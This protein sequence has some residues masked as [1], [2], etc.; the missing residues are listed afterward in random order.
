MFCS[1][2]TGAEYQIEASKMKLWV[3]HARQV[4]QV[5]S[6]SEPFLAGSAQHDASL[7]ILEERDK[8]ALS[9]VINK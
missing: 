9:V 4:V 7:S 8:D 6:N 5:V 1:R 3:K 2:I